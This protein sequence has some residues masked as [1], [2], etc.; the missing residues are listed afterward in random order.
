MQ[1]STHRN[2]NTTGKI[3]KKF[4]S[5]NFYPFNINRSKRFE[6][7]KTVNSNHQ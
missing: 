3:L 1:D 4:V 6:I 5:F 2:L 7:N